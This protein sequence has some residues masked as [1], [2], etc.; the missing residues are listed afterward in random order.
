ME[1]GGYWVPNGT[2][3][4]WGCGP[5]LGGWKYD[6]LPEAEILVGAYCVDP[7]A[8]RLI[9]AS[10]QRSSREDC[11]G[12]YPLAVEVEDLYRRYQYMPKRASRRSI[13]NGTMTPIAIFA[14]RES[15][16]EVE[17]FALA[18]E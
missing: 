11:C 15:P 5:A 17:L 6:W 16:W 1:T 9:W 13:T 2:E 4:Y 10:P 18:I 8:G 7:P 14:P 3:E 12:R